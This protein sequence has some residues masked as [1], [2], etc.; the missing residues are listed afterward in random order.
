MSDNTEAI[1]RN[2]LTDSWLA[3]G[4]RDKHD[5]EAAKNMLLRHGTWTPEEWV[6]AC[7]VCADYV[8]IFD[9]IGVMP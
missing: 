5:Y 2:I 6:E 7:R 3:P 4:T 1:A 9:V 8:G